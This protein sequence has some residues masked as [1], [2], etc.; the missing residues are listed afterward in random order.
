MRAA[1]GGHRQ[2]DQDQRL[3]ALMRFGDPRGAM[4]TSSVRRPELDQVLAQEFALI[5]DA[6]LWREL[7]ELGGVW[8]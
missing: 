3:T 2:P 6:G 8:E 5:R 4:E 1:P 7:R